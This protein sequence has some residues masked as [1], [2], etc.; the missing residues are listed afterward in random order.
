[1]SLS[2][3]M[4][5]DIKINKTQFLAIF[6]MAFLG[7][8]AYCGIYGEYYGLEQT[9]ADF[10]AQT[11]LADG[12]VYNTDFD[13]SS[14][15]KIGEFTTQT[16]RQNVVR[17][18]ASM[19][20]KPDITL[21]FTE[22]GTISKF[23]TTKGEDFNPDDDSGV[24]LDERF[25]EER[26]LDVGDKITFEFDDYKIKKEIKGIGYSPEYIYEA[27]TSTLTPDFSQ[28][29]FA[30]LSYKAY[31]SDLEYNTLLVKYNSSD[32]D[33]KDKLDDSIDYLSFTKQ[34]DQISVSKFSDE[35]GQHKMMGD[36]FPI[37]FI[38]VTFLTLLTTMTRI[39]SHQRTQIGILKAVGF[40]D[41]T[42]ILHYLSYGFWPVLAG[43]VL[44]LITGPM[45]IPRMFY[46]TMTKTYSLPVWNPGFDMSFV[47]LASLM[48][49]LSVF[50]TY[51]SCRRISK[52]NPANTM[53]PKAPNLSS[54]SFIERSALWN[55]LS[56]NI[57]WNIRDARMNKF[58]AFMV[59][60][61]VMGCVGLLIAAFGMNDSMDE[62]KSWEY[63]DIS[64]FESK[65]QISNNANPLELYYILNETNGSFIMQQSIEIKANGIEDMVGLLATN[66][67]DLI[68]YTDSNRNP[69][70]I[71]EGDVSISTKLAEKFNLTIGDKIKWHIVGEDKW[72]TSKIG[73]IHSEPISQGLIM[74][75]DTLEDQGL[76]FTP[77][78]IL[79]S[80]K[81][82]ENFDSI[83][84]VTSIEKLEKSWDQI[85]TAV[86]MM[87]YVVTV[88][89]VAL[90][91]LVLY[92]LGILSFTEMEREIATLKVLGFKTR[93]LRKLLLTQNLI[94]T[95][96]GF[97]L[98][99]PLGFYFMTLMMNAA[100]DSL[101][102]VPTL[103][104]GN[105]LLTAFITFT[106][107]IA[108]NLMFSDKI[109]DL[110]MVEALKDVD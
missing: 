90:A 12:W 78:N 94:F 5:R 1:M 79:T 63:D 11:N 7:I 14:V 89:A 44:G 43:A 3:K 8:F 69:I 25:A 20:G 74:S 96:I 21:H 52:E 93:V 30:Y 6:M 65:L 35:M 95:A 2:K 88:V 73:Q 10:Y 86:M 38:I 82:G 68:S 24:W 47:Y 64:H 37:V 36:V 80:E 32:N 70:D 104:W 16:D 98:G 31:P 77:T 109:N 42:I 81:F 59:I 27:S 110:N 66:N 85:I 87:V 102:Y 9:S 72:V 26:N 19:E 53:R 62:L 97:I 67:T 108:V 58:R 18:V 57:R 92:N 101:Y 103:T 15:E 41:R 106:V 49:I 28:M 107:S 48:V 56:F 51:M 50:V 60:I 45:I 71:D 54:K 84:S 46:P 13:D 99:I 91:I 23:Y 83:K 76:N 29:G 33:F 100:G 17:S 4:L 105:I 75:P 55:R 34:E 61:G 39:V 22:K 40:K